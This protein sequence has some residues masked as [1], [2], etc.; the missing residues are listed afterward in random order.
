M[1]RLGLDYNETYALTL[2]L[3]TYKLILSLVT[4]YS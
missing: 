4:Y 1:Q 2:K 3:I